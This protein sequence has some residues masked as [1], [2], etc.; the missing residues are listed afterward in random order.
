[1]CIESQKTPIR[2][3][4]E[5]LDA[6][7]HNKG[8]SRE[9]LAQIIVEAHEASDGPRK[10]RVQ[11]DSG[12]TDVFKRAH[13]NAARI[14]RWFN[15]DEKDTNLLSVNFLQTVLIAMPR[16]YAITW[17]NTF[18]R[19]LGLGAHSLNSKTLP[20]NAQS[21]LVTLLKE[22]S[23]SH[24]AVA[25]LI[26]DQSAAALEAAHRE[27]TDS[28]EASTRVRSEIEAKIAGMTKADQ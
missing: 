3:L 2:S 16:D 25:G 13:T 28:I 23:E 19:P 9:T 12:I 10:L 6:W 26:A 21:A 17:L 18:L 20:L 24:Q 15:D 22:D 1:M 27:L 4:L 8:W 7:R 5:H 11:F 14:F